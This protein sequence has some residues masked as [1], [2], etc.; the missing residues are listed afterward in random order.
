MFPSE[1]PTSND[2]LRATV[3]AP[4]SG[5]LPAI[6]PA[7]LNNPVAIKHPHLAIIEGLSG[8]LIVMEDVGAPLSQAMQ[9]P[10]FR[11]HWAQSA[12]LRRAFFSDIGLSALNLVVE[13]GL[14]H[15]DVR[16]PNI[17]FRSD[18][19]C[20]IDFDFSR[21]TILSNEL[22]AFALSLSKMISL[23]NSE[24][25]RANDG[26]FSCSDRADSLRAERS[27]DI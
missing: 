2:G 23:N 20:L 8:P 15:N 9:S 25:V 10:Q 6:T 16:P 12:S 24:Q 17:A 11:Q 13:V 4:Q 22:S 5:S 7:N 14:C 26:L 27:K 18:S 1:L 19:F 21:R 3:P